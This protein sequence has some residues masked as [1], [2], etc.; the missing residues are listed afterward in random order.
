MGE[1][2]GLI[3]RIR[4]V[5]R[6]AAGA[7]ASARRS[8]VDPQDGRGARDERMDA[9]E[10][11]IAHL[12]GLV[13]GLQDSVHRESER[14]AKLITELQGQIQPGAMGAALAEDARSRGL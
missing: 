2:E 8:T 3:A 6:S 1:R 14:H 13:E 11:R 10:A 12:E 4:Q 9:L 5:R 7:D